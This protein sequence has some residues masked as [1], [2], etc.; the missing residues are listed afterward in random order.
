MVV[1]VVKFLRKTVVKF[2]RK[3]VVKFVRKTVVKFVRKTVVK[4][5]CCASPVS[6]QTGPTEDVSARHSQTGLPGN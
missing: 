1:T 6:D 5:V 2:V 4:P 3:T